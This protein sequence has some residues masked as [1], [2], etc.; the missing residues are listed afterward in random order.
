MNARI[1][2]VRQGEFAPLVFAYHLRRIIS[3][4]GKVG[5][6]DNVAMKIIVNEKKSFC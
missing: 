2:G 4:E 6:V 5:Y 3:N 1:H